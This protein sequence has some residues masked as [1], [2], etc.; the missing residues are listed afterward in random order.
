MQ[1]QIYTPPVRKTSLMRRILRKLGLFWT[2]VILTLTSIAFSLLLTNLVTLGV[3]RE[4][5]S[6]TGNTIAF[7]VPAILAPSLGALNLRLLFHLD[8]AEEHLRLLSVRDDLTGAANRRQFIL[9]AQQE[10]ERANRYGTVFSIA[11]MDIDDFKDVND[12]YGHLA[13]DQVL[14][15]LAQI[16]MQNVRTVDTFA[17]YAGDEFVVLMPETQSQRAWDCV[18]RMRAIVSSQPVNY[19]SRAINYTISAGVITIDSRLQDLETL[20]MYVDRALY[21]AKQM[22]K[23]Q[24]RVS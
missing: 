6:A 19:D 10:I 15:H 23:N 14:S 2:T 16:G 1:D 11:F 12:T 4:L 9:Q 22:G 5:A 21:S 13:G 17:R 3:D 24:V 7:V 18:E 20:L 8:T